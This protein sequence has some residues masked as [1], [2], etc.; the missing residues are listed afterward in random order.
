MP[1]IIA[2]I[3]LKVSEICLFFTIIPGLDFLYIYEEVFMRKTR[4]LFGVLVLLGASLYAQTITF[5]PYL[6]FDWDPVFYDPGTGDTS[7][8]YRSFNFDQAGL[9]VTGVLGKATAYAEVRGFPSGSNTY[10][11]YD[12]SAANQITSFTK[13]IY[14]AWGK[15]QFTETG[16][17]WAG[18][19]KPSF[20]PILF[21]SSH[22]GI[23]WQ[24]KIPGGHT[25]SGYVFQPSVNINVFNPM[26]WWALKIPE[27]RGIRFLVLEEYVS[28]TFMLFGG[29][30]YD[31]LG[32]EYSKLHF[33][34]FAAY[35]G[36]PKLTLSA[37][38]AA[39]VYIKEDGVVKDAAKPA[40][41]DNAGLGL[42]AYL[43]AEYQLLDPLALGATF[44]LLDPLVGAAKNM[45]QAGKNVQAVLDGEIS[46]ATVGLYCKF[47]PARGFYIQP[48]I[49]IKFA[50][51][52][53]GYT[54][55]NGA[56]DGQKAGL[57]FTLTFRWE[58]SI[59]IGG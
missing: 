41:A 28:K 54:P 47:A 19:F 57:D 33:N 17:I 42:G 23:G 49:N 35:L 7:A 40:E 1:V 13:P 8:N 50:N 43:S 31:Y 32:N 29:A 22:F 16:N 56:E 27:D 15:Y 36:V 6:T 46:A 55:K 12:G 59:R 34:V 58:P 2:K 52:I 26:G 9:K 44:K 37:E 25:L 5:Q 45:P 24:Q 14:Y 10:N 30:S 18:K 53:N 11:V 4:L 3:I 38:L 51:A 39:A 20:G 21:D 48:A